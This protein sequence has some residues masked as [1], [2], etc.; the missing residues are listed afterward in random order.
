[1]SPP[2]EDLHLLKPLKLYVRMCLLKM[3]LVPGNPT[4]VS[5]HVSVGRICGPTL[6]RVEC[7]TGLAKQNWNVCVVDALCFSDMPEEQDCEVDIVGDVDVSST[8]FKAVS[9]NGTRCSGGEMKTSAESRTKIC[10]SGAKISDKICL[11][12]KWITDVDRIQVSEERRKQMMRKAR[13]ISRSISKKAARSKNSLPASDAEHSH[14]VCDLSPA[15]NKP[16]TDLVESAVKTDIKPR[17]TGKS[18]WRI[19]RV[20]NVPLVADTVGT[21]DNNR[22]LLISKVPPPLPKDSFSR[23]GWH[24]HKTGLSMEINGKTSHHPST[25]HQVLDIKTETA[26]LGSSAS[27]RVLTVKSSQN[28]TSDVAEDM[29]A[30]GLLVS[31]PVEVETEVRKSPCTDN[32][33]YLQSLLRDPSR[34]MIEKIQ[35]SSKQRSAILLPNAVPAR[36]E[37][38]TAV[39]IEVPSQ[40]LNLNSNTTQADSFSTTVSTEQMGPVFVNASVPSSPCTLSRQSIASK[41]RKLNIL[42]Y[43]SILPHRQKKL[44]QSAEM[45]KPEKLSTAPVYGCSKDILHDHDYGSDRKH[46]FGFGKEQSAENPLVLPRSNE[47]RGVTVIDAFSKIMETAPST[48]KVIHNEAKR[49]ITSGISVNAGNLNPFTTTSQSKPT[50][51]STSSTF[52]FQRELTVGSKTGENK[53]SP[54]A[55]DVQDVTLDCMPAYF[56]VISLPNQQTKISI[57]AATLVTKKKHNPQSLIVSVDCDSAKELPE[58]HTDNTL[59]C[60]KDVESCIIVNSQQSVDSEAV[61]VKDRCSS[62]ASSVSSAISISSDEE[63]SRS[64]SSSRRCST[65][66]SSYSSDSSW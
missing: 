9:S 28:V 13:A 61:V 37:H 12:S 21:V 22:P 2:V 58:D 45:T 30:D 23:S 6:S 11:N 41:K 55:A 1:M 31:S 52:E 32:S 53:S 36:G 35:S 65:C 64:S 10:V 26:K 15:E 46:N 66:E 56:D 8:Q 44:M 38:E 24:S 42:Q 33:G 34:E 47:T 43:K 3:H 50:A 19:P 27:S 51:L 16:E 20:E 48:A 39:G 54:S 4:P 62:R 25:G 14:T 49:N 17:D 7:E 57:S 59:Q 29:T 18:V 40:N 63:S 60:E 5:P